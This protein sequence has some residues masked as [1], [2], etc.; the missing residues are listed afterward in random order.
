MLIISDIEWNEFIDENIVSQDVID[1][2]AIRIKYN[3][4]LTDRELAIY[5]ERSEKN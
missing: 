4:E 2:I 3:F 5:K 1:I